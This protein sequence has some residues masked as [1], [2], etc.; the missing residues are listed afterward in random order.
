MAPPRVGTGMVAALLLAGRAADVVAQSHGSQP[1]SASL[2]DDVAILLAFQL[3]NRERGA[4]RV[5][6]LPR[7]CVWMGAL[8]AAGGDSPGGSTHA[9]VVGS[10]I[11]RLPEQQAH[12]SAP[13]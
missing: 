5:V 3:Q 6:I 12:S 1:P 4:A 2:E 11:L 10:R 13:R 7:A 9:P 8:R